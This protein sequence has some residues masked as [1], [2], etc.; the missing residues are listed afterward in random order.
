MRPDNIK[1][2]IIVN[3]DKNPVKVL[4]FD[5]ISNLVE[6]VRVDTNERL[7]VDCE[8]LTED[9]QLHTDCLSYY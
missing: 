7:S 4:S 5:E 6:L 3:H 2:G 8:E 9:P 1:E